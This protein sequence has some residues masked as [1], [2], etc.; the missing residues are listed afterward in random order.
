[1]KYCV[2]YLLSPLPSLLC[3]GEGAAAGSGGAGASGAGPGRAEEAVSGSDG[4]SGE[5]E[6]RQGAGPGG[7]RCLHRRG[8]SLKYMAGAEE[9][10]L[11]DTIL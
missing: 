6:G 10:S 8:K 4:D 11:C 5:A 9:S 3:R 1:M 2:V 7:R